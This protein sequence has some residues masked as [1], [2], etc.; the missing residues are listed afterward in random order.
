MLIPT[1]ND[2]ELIP[3]GTYTGILVELLDLGSQTGEYGTKRNIRLAWEIVGQLM[4]NG[5]PFIASRQFNLTVGQGSSLRPYIEALLGHSINPKEALNTRDLL[6]K[7][8]LISVQHKVSD[9]KTYANIVG[10]LPIPAGTSVPDPVS[11][12]VHFTLDPEEFDE[13][14]F[15][16]LPEWKQK[17]IGKSP[18][19]MNLV[20][21]KKV[22]GSGSELPF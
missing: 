20:A 17:V 15:R 14:L 2:F 11:K 7:A 19:W 16:G 12:I 13:E 5:K 18:E 1:N 22:G 10:C 21:T 6:G 3:E 9:G 4:T 8:C